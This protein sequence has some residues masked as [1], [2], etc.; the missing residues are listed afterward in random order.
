MTADDDVR[1]AMM[2]AMASDDLWLFLEIE[3]DERATPGLLLID[4]YA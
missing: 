3:N 4:S 2:V 1:F